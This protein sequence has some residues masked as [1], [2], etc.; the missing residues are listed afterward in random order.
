MNDFDL[1]ISKDRLTVYINL[2]N[3]DKPEIVSESEINELLSSYGVTFGIKKDV[4]QQ[5]ASNLSVTSYPLLIAE[6]QP[7]VKGQNGYLKLEV[8]VEGTKESL[9]EE[10]FNLRDIIKIPSVTKG[11]LVATIFSNTP[12]VP[13]KDVHG[14]EIQAIDGKPYRYRIGK[15]TIETNSRIY[16]TLDGQ[17][18]FLNNNISV[19]PLFE[20]QGDLDLKTGNID[21][22][23]NVTI[24][25]NVPSGYTIKAGGDVSI[26]GLVEAAEIIAGGSIFISGGIVGSN[27]GRLI[28]KGDIVASYI[29]QSHIEAGNNL[30]V[31]GSILHSHCTTKGNINSLKG[32]IIGGVISAGKNLQIHNIGNDLHTKTEVFVGKLNEIYE[33]EKSIQKEIEIA[34][35]DLQKLVIIAKKIAEKYKL[36]SSLSPEEIGFLKRQKV[37]EGELIDR[38]NDL[39]E[40]YRNIQSQI[41]SAFESSLVVSGSLYP[42]VQLHFGKYQRITNQ[43]FRGVCIKLLNKE[44]TISALSTNQKIEGELVK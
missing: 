32:S 16:A 14:N 38:I 33:E 35:N 44:I 41:N 26:Y 18:S 36:T 39:E 8:N 29:N 37:T 25:G 21:F 15:N 12:G 7:P 30:E 42:N 10:V 13:G 40:K 2:I 23:G 5:I 31:S 22:I 19:Q 6:G 28:A 34:R 20:V 9:T 43:V 24:R 27:K 11:Q 17:V 3:E 4:I 1:N